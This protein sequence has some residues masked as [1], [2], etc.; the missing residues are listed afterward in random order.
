MSVSTS[1]IGDDQMTKD[2]AA[3]RPNVTKKRYVKPTLTIYGTVAAL[4]QTGPNV[5]NREANPRRPG[6]QP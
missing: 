2:E 1:T 6:S 4:T 5:G 3:S